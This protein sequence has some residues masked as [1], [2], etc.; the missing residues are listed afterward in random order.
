MTKRNKEWCYM[1]IKLNSINSC[2]RRATS[3]SPINIYL[4]MHQ[5]LLQQLLHGPT[6]YIY[7]IMQ[8]S[9]YN[10]EKVED[11]FHKAN[12]ENTIITRHVRKGVL[13]WVSAMSSRNSLFSNHIHCNKYTMPILR[14]ACNSHHQGCFNV[15]GWRIS[16]C[17]YS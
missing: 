13:G 17:Y 15:C 11:Q 3:D 5:D 10:H 4:Y 16:Y 14:H 12:Q 9:N 8:Y 1:Y 6:S 2:S 7:R